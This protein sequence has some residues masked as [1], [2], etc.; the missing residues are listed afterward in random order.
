MMD[1]QMPFVPFQ[2]DKHSY[3]LPK[4][5]RSSADLAPPDFPIPPPELRLGYGRTPEE[6][7][8]NGRR[9]VQTML[10]LLRAAGARLDRGIRILDFG[11]GA[12]R[13][14]RW[15]ADFASHG[16]VW[17]TDISAE[18]IVWCM[19]HLAPPFHFLVNTVLPH[20]PFEERL[21]ACQEVSALD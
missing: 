14:I 10:D 4:M 3:V 12:G 6:Y 19:Q 17:G 13:M 2:R 11:C 16:E 8:A 5:S 18:H 15:L 21:A 1:S 7:L 9:N 20:L